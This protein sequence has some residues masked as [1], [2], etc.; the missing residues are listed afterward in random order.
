MTNVKEFQCVTAQENEGSAIW[1]GS[2]L[3]CT[4]PWISV[5]SISGPK[6]LFLSFQFEKNTPFP[7]FAFSNVLYEY[8]AKVSCRTSDP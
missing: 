2:D 1:R 4:L 7:I 3:S 6:I 5:S 8:K